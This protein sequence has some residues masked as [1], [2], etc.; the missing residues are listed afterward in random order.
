M[1]KKKS[2]I[3]IVTASREQLEC[4]H[5]KGIKVYPV[6]ISMKMYVEVDNNGKLTKYATPL[7]KDSINEAINKT[8]IFWYNKLKQAEKNQTK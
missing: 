4:I 5:Q 8:C 6:H 3:S 1:P 7:T 2:S